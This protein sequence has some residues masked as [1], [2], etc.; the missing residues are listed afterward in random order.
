MA[1]QPK[2][3]TSRL[4]G[5]MA[6]KNVSQTELAKELGIDPSTL[7]RKITGKTDFSLIEALTIIRVLGG[8]T[9]DDYFFIS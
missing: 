3:N 9:I 2:L 5:K 8:G 1:R 7:S 6:E 4:R